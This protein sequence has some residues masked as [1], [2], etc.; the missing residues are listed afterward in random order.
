MRHPMDVSAGAPRK[1]GGP[2]RIDRAMIVDAALALDPATLTM[3]AVA[4]HL[5]VDRKALN[6]HV[7][8]REGLLR[9]MTARAFENALVGAFAQTDAHA[10]SSTGWRAAI[11]T[12]VETF[13]DTLV[14]TGVVCDY[15][16]IVG[17][18]PSVLDPAERVLN[19]LLRAGFDLTTA[20]RALSLATRL[21]MC[22]ARDVLQLRQDHE[23]PQA[24]EVRRVLAS[25]DQHDARQALRGLALL[26]VGS[27]HDVDQQL[28]F[29]IDVLL[30]GLEA[31]LA[32]EHDD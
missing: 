10:T 17:D 22:G 25:D 26:D 23:H 8:D 2:R 29:E 32:S 15:F 21:A 5:G 9:L 4:R 7:T 16:P 20:G 24:V 30:A 6:Y 14:A 3:Q 1:R 31:R 12:W 13:R 11:T 18:D 19:V 28:Q 27:P